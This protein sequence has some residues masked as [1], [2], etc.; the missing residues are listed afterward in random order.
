MSGG[1]LR[2]EEEDQEEEMLGESS[3]CLLLLLFLSSTPL[4]FL[5]FTKLTEEEGSC[6]LAVYRP[7]CMG[8]L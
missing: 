8:T 6:L 1:F 5:S 7:A 2:D 4:Y 3:V